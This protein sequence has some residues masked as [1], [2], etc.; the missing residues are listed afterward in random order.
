MSFESQIIIIITIKLGMIPSEISVHW[1]VPE[2][3]FVFDSH[4]NLYD[5]VVENIDT[6]AY[7]PVK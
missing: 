1:K 6:Q 7:C 3:V 4:K 5:V 2:I